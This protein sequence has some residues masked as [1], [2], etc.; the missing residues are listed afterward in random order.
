[1][2]C[3]NCGQLL[4]EGDR[5]CRFCGTAL[6]MP[7]VPKKGSRWVPIVAMVLLCALCLAGLFAYRVSIGHTK[8]HGDTAPAPTAEPDSDPLEGEE[9]GFSEDEPHSSER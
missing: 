2:Y 1:M 5:F 9:A 8:E 3:Y 6:N 7:P 4:D